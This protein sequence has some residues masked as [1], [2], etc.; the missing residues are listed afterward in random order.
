MTKYNR[1]YNID[2]SFTEIE[3]I[4]QNQATFISKNRK[5]GRKKK[6]QP[7]LPVLYQS[8]IQS[9]KP[10][11]IQHPL[12]AFHKWFGCRQTQWKWHSCQ[13]Q[14]PWSPNWYLNPTSPTQKP[15]HK[16]TQAKDETTIKTPQKLEAGTAPQ[17][18]EHAHFTDSSTPN[19]W[20]HPRESPHLPSRNRQEKIKTKKKA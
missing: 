2:R 7:N 19:A 4:T 5:R 12:L 18:I 17:Q 13:T 16:H 10:S 11:E 1:D 20:W 14:W 15:I 6:V 8:L 3:Q 9:H